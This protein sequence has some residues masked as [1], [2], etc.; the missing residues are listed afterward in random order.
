MKILLIHSD[1]NEEAIRQLWPILKETQAVMEILLVEPLNGTV[2]DIKKQ[3]ADFFTSTDL[4]G[5]EKAGANT[6]SHILVVSPIAG[7]WLDF[8][9]GYSYG[10]HLPLLV[11]GKQAIAAMPVEFAS[12][13][14]ALGSEKSLEEYFEAEKEAFENWKGASEI[15]K[16]RETL[17]K[18]GIPVTGESLAN[19]SGEGNVMEVSLFL[20][21]GFSPD[22]RDKAGIPLLNI[23]ARKENWEIFLLLIESGAQV[24]LTADDRGTTALLD[25][26]MKKNLN[27]VNALIKAGAE[28]NI[29]SKDGQTALILAVG[30]GD[31][32]VTD[33]LLKA[34]ADPDIPD[35]MGVSARK[36][37]ALFNK[38]AMVALFD[39]YPPLSESQK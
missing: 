37:A 10:A 34:G 5:K 7:R 16:A 22:T 23:A 33:A 18:M 38:K 28:L 19:R 15:M 25:S 35:G 30:A 4:K 6:L 32:G 17:L 24:N 39:A 13:F 29:K 31:S 12:F 14:R 21:A 8:L 20:T 11:Y 26:V 3:F 9:A 2:G 1:K 36:Y 27:M